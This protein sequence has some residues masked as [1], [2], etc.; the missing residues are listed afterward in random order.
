MSSDY[1]RTSVIGYNTLFKNMSLML[2]IFYRN[3]FILCKTN[4]NLLIFACF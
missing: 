4:N 2:D 1:V 3:T